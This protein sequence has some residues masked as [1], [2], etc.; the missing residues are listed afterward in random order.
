MHRI[1]RLILCWSRGGGICI[2]NRHLSTARVRQPFKY[3]PLDLTNNEIRLL[4]VLPAK[5]Q[6]LHC[7]LSHASLDHPPEYHALS[8]AWRDDDLFSSQ[9]ETPSLRDSESSEEIIV[10]NERL[11]VGRNL[12]SALKARRSHQ[13]RSIPL[14][15]DA[16]SINQEEIYERSGQILRMRDIYARASKVTVWLGPERDHSDKA[17]Q[18]IEMIHTRSKEFEGWIK[19]SSTGGWTKDTSAFATW[20]EE[21]LVQ[22]RHP[23][24]WQAVY[25]LLRRA[26]WKRIWIVQEM[27]AARNVV[28]FCGER[29]LDPVHLSGF[30]DLLVAHGI[31]YLPLLRNI[32]GIVLEYDTFSLA[33][34]Y[35]RQETWKRVSLL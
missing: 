11:K 22:R 35:L 1:T 30:F 8:Y 20:F 14:W 34:A 9:D 16:I 25:R 6:E 5:S 12:A 7:S 23:L 4:T 29:T 17:L 3:T 27:V 15:V 32:E 13:F 26:W 21:S 10:N 28:L 24:E 2:Q 33:R 31:M 18:F 19:D